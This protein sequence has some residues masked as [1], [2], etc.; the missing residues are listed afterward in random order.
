M[1]T[2]VIL[3]CIRTSTEFYD[4]ISNSLL[5]SFFQKYGSIKTVQIFQKESIIKAFIEFS[6]ISGAKNVLN[7]FEDH[8]AY[9]GMIRVYHSKKRFIINNI[10]TKNQQNHQNPQN[11]LRDSTSNINPKSKASAKSQLTQRMDRGA[12]KEQTK[13]G[14]FPNQPFDPSIDSVNNSHD[15]GDVKTISYVLNQNENTGNSQLNSDNQNPVP[16]I[17]SKTCYKIN[18]PVIRE[19]RVLH[20]DG[21]NFNKVRRQHLVNIFECFGIITK[22]AINPEGS[23]ALIEFESQEHMKKAANA[24]R[25]IRFYGDILKISIFKQKTSSQ[26]DFPEF[27]RNIDCFVHQSSHAQY[28]EIRPNFEN[29]RPSNILLAKHVPPGM[30]AILICDLLSLSH[31]PEIVRKIEQDQNGFSLFLIEFKLVSEAVEVLAEFQHQRINQC[32]LILSFLNPD[33][34]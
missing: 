26:V 22:L 33:F 1:E 14:D 10:H 16:L 25:D 4:Q 21:L 8:S 20:I 30:S 31:E 7:N 18:N 13:H 17:D 29:T 9:F 34:I 23:F 11:L 2:K 12:N 27:R 19:N 24:L 28:F 6:D 5:I 32:C 3:C 15:N